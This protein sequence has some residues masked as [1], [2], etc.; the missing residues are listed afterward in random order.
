MTEVKLERP[1]DYMTKDEIERMEYLQF[2]KEK[3]FKEFTDER[4]WELDELQKRHKAMEERIAAEDKESKSQKRR[5]A[6]QV[7][8]K[9][10]AKKK[11]VAKKKVAVKKATKKTV[12]KA[13]SKKK[14]K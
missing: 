14:R 2:A 3:G 7:K 6:V 1:I 8:A 9:A 10:K 12:K 13:S 11:E 4:Q 5:K